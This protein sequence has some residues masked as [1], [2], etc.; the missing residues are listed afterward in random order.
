[1]QWFSH[2]VD[3]FTLKIRQKFL[4]FH[5]FESKQMSLTQDKWSLEQSSALQLIV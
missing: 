3:V 1:M 5:I 4:D 2:S